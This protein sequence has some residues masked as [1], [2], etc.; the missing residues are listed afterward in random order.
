M[1]LGANHTILTLMRS[2]IALRTLTCGIL[3]LFLHNFNVGAP[4]YGQPKPTEHAQSGGKSIYKIKKVVLDAGHGGKDPGCIGGHSKEKH[5]TLAIALRVG[6]YIKAN[7][8]EIE[9]I[10]TRDKDEFIELNE[11]AAIANRNKADLFISIHCNSIPSATVEGSETYVLG[12]HRAEDNLAVA[13]REN[14]SIYL[15]ENYKQNYGGYDPASPEAHIMSAMWQSA[16]LE[17]SILFASYI[18][19][20]AHATAARKDKGVRQAGFLVLRETAMPA[21]LFETGYLTNNKEDAFLASEEGRDLMARAI[22]EGFRD[23]KVHME[24][25]SEVLAKQEARKRPTIVPPPPPAAPKVVAVKQSVPETQTPVKT[26]V[27]PP[28]KNTPESVKPAPPAPVKEHYKI[29]LMSWASK[30]DRNT[31]KFALLDKVEEVFA[32]GKY[33]YFYGDYA[34]RSEAEKILPEIQ[35][36]GFKGATVQKAK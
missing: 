11:R 5:N 8:P 19:Q 12:L 28:V 26:N 9:V 16:Y 27:A 23:Y 6:Q 13:K 17:Q 32:D 29:L 1:F 33:H 22:Y 34:Q 15:E 35:N 3:W 4:L 2:K 20:Y 36:L 25:G 21:A 10:Y 31:G 14:A 18:Q 30:V 24:T 7:F